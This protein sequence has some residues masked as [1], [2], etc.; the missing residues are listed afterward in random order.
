MYSYM[1]GQPFM[2]PAAVPGG[3]AMSG[4]GM[5]G[6]AALYPQQQAHLAAAHLASPPQQ[7]QRGCATGGYAYGMGGAAAGVYH[8]PTQQQQQQQVPPYNEPA[9][10]QQQQAP[11]VPRIAP[12]QESD[13]WQGG[14]GARE[15]RR[16]WRSAGSKWGGGGGWGGSSSK[17]KWGDGGKDWQDK[18]TQEQTDTGGT[19][20]LT[21]PKETVAVEGSRPQAQASDQVR[22][23]E[24]PPGGGEDHT[25]P[26]AAEPAKANADKKKKEEKRSRRVG[27]P[28]GRTELAAVLAP[29]IRTRRRVVGEGTWYFIGLEVVAPWPADMGWTEA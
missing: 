15:Y 29:Q 22:N 19:S 18:A 5:G 7:Q 13:S 23:V 12:P 4:C 20:D 6:A 16:S 28:W 8:Q 27:P 1:M 17:P 9:H 10:Q 26:T 24:E 11:P 21:K 25:E 2:H 14:L 3:C